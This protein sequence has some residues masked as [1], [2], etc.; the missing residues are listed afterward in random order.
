MGK[1]CEGSEA[2]Y[3]GE[4]EHKKTEEAVLGEIGCKKLTKSFIGKIESSEVV[5]QNYL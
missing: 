2:N 4:N 5:T 1:F 3:A